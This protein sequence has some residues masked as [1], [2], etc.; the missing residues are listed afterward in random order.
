MNN[1][2]H[3]GKESNCYC[4]LSKTL[5]TLDYE[6]RIAQLEKKLAFI[7]D[8]LTIFDGFGDGYIIRDQLGWYTHT[9]EAD[10]VCFDINCNDLFYWAS[11]DGEEITPDNVQLLKDTISEM[12]Q[13][14]K[15]LCE[16]K[17][18][19]FCCD[20]K[21]HASE[22]AGTLF[23]CRSR[24]MR[25]QPPWYKSYPEY[26]HPLFDACGPEVMPGERG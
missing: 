14:E 23:C 22:Y 15:R 2:K 17:N 13:L 19:K 26:M 7:K 9:E 20:N 4:G 21:L 18:Y 8:V 12:A 6:N 10:P 24:K 11:A 16:G 3:C 1:C 5:W 25:P